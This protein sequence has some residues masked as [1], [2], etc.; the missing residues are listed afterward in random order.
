L[1]GPYRSN[2][3]KQRTG[4]SNA[5]H[6]TGLDSSPH[7]TH[8]PVRTESPASKPHRRA[9]VEVL[10]F[11]DFCRCDLLAATPRPILDKIVTALVEAPRFL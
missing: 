8:P 11:V 6:Q 2:E 5:R 1:L 10:N 7:L 9:S 3:A 4:Q